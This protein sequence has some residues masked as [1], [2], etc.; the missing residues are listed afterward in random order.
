MIECAN[1]L[2]PKLN[3]VS[4]FRDFWLALGGCSSVARALPLLCV[5]VLEK[6][7][8]QLHFPQRVGDTQALKQLFPI[9][10]YT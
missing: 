3:S 5:C 10:F 9:H 4:V 6:G 2:C 7:A 8:S 1:W